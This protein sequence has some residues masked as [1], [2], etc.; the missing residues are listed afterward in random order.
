MCRRPGWLGI[1][2]VSS[3]RDE[4]G[5]GLRA[6]PFERPTALFRTGCR[7]RPRTQFPV[8]VGLV[9]P[10]RVI[11]SSGFQH[12]GS[13]YSLS[14]RDCQQPKDSQPQFQQVCSRC[15]RVTINPQSTSNVLVPRLLAPMYTSPVCVHY[16]LFPN[17]QCHPHVEF[18]T[19]QKHRVFF[20]LG[21]LFV[22]QHHPDYV[23]CSSLSHHDSAAGTF[24]TRPRRSIAEGELALRSGA[25]CAV[26][27]ET[28]RVGK[29]AAVTAGAEPKTG[30]W[31]Y[32]GRT[33]MPL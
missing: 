16:S 1:N 30:K 22:V 13:S 4:S 25:C 23:R 20:V 19:L 27:L 24:N 12:Y 9:L 7:D 8:S 14:C 17:A 15:L 18:W 10:G 2:I 31:T 32:V 5:N 29:L 21:R 33:A 26:E 11:R 28:G 3:Q 6:Q